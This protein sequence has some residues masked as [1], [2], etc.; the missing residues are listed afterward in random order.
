MNDSLLREPQVE[1]FFQAYFIGMA[2]GHLPFFFDDI[3]F[4]AFIPK[5]IVS[6]PIVFILFIFYRVKYSEINSRPV[7]W[8]FIIFIAIL[9]LITAAF[10]LLS[11]G[12]IQRLTL[13]AFFLVISLPSVFVAC[14]YFTVM[15]RLRLRGK[16]VR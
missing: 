11:G 13:L 7:L 9:L 6:L 12:S 14:M 10:L 1:L 2:L 8:S 15:I 3:G 4:I 5:F 16:A